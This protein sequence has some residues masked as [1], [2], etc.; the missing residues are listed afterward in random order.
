MAILFGRNQLPVFI[1]FLICGVISGVVY[2][3][4]R[5]KRRIV[6]ANNIVL[7]FDDMA[8]MLFN[9]VLVIFNAYAFNNG[10]LK[11]YEFPLMLM[12]FSVYRLT[13]SVLFIK[14]VFKVI[15]VTKHLILR[16]VISPVA[17]LF[18][19]FKTELLNLCK[20]VYLK[21]VFYRNKSAFLHSYKELR[22]I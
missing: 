2:D 4:L 5:I 13:L 20:S 22:R 7:F 6:P 3:L 8:F 10:N 16:F 15:D 1:S 9:A 12:G 19:R 18:N 14:I 17:R 21:F 11:W